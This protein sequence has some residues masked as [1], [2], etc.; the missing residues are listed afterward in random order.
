MSENRILTFSETLDS[1]TKKYIEVLKEQE[2][3][4]EEMNYEL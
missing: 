4:K 2:K 1:I 3:F